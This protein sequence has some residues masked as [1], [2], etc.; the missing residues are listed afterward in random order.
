[1][2]FLGTARHPTV[3]LKQAPLTV[4]LNLT[5]SNSHPLLTP[6]IPCVFS[7]LFSYCFYVTLH[8]I[9]SLVLLTVFAPRRPSFIDVQ[10][11]DSLVQSSTTITIDLVPFVFTFFAESS[12]K[13]QSNS[14]LIAP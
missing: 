12:V 4:F 10:L 6:D 1:M 11:A 9:N 14:P 2:A 5:V 8:L 3:N 7:L 13:H